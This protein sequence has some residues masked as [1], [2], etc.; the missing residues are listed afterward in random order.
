VDTLQQRFGNVIRRRRLAVPLGQ[1]ALADKAGLHRTYISMLERGQRMPSLAVVRK[2]AEAL[3]TTMAS[4]IIELEER[5]GSSG[6]EKG[7]LPPGRR[8]GQGERPKPAGPSGG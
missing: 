3:G 6:R 5:K 1:E 4:L 8:T 2:L 7:R